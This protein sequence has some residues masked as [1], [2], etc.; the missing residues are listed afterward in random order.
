[1]QSREALQLETNRKLAE[2]VALILRHQ[3]KKCSAGTENP[4]YPIRKFHTEFKS[5]E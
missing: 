3:G 5:L 1:M 4:E 2:H